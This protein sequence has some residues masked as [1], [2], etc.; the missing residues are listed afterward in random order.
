MISSGFIDTKD[1]DLMTSVIV[2]G[3]SLGLNLV[4]SYT[5]WKNALAS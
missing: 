5:S 4:T 3:T 1:P 2:F